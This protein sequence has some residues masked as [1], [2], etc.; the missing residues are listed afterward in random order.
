MSFYAGF[1]MGGTELK[2]GLVSDE[3]RI[4]HSGNIKTPTKINSLLETLKDIWENLKKQSSKNVLSA[5]F[6][7]PG[8]FSR[9]EEKILQSPNYPELD[10]F[11]LK[12]ALAKFIDVPFQLNNDANMAAFGEY[13]AGAGKDAHSMV[14]LTIGTGVGSGIILEG[15][16]WQGKCGFAGE[17]G[18]ITVNTEGDP[19]N[20]GS[21]GCLETEVSSWKIISTYKED[22]HH[23]D[24]IT[25]KEV[26]SRAKK[27]DPSATKAVSR[28]G[29]FLGIGLAS[30]INL[31]NPE[32]IILGG[33]IMKSGDY[34]LPFVLDE[35]EKRSYG[36]SFRCCKI[37]NAVLGNSA[38][39]IGAALW[40]QNQI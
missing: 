36:A 29:Y 2:Y 11:A 6:G 19:C 7:I 28:A 3:G 40:S 12:P 23:K 27:G 16:L 33:G 32:K 26:F 9:S 39:L 25:A 5:G 20:C 1:D 10:G 37:V 30:V 15:N 14:M 17:L 4:I 38:G 8:I 13:K 34:F 21:R 24:M 35:T 18:H 31:L 22:S